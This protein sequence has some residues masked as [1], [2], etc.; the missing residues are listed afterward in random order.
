MMRTS[1]SPYSSLIH[2]QERDSAGQTDCMPAFLVI[3]NRIQV[4]HRP[5]IN[6]DPQG[7]SGRNVVLSLVDA[8]LA[9]I[10]YELHVYIQNCSTK[11]LARTASGLGLQCGQQPLAHWPVFL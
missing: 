10:P 4:R 7:G 9:F 2:Q 1:S 3:Y 6:K 5:W 11:G 8:V